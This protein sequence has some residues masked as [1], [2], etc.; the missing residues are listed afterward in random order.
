[1]FSPRDSST[2]LGMTAV[3]LLQ[4][5]SFWNENAIEQIKTPLHEQRQHSSGNRTL[6]N[7]HVI[8]QVKTAYDRFAQTASADQRGE[9]GSSNINHG[10]GFDSGEDGSRCHR[11]K[12]LPKAR[13]WA[14]SQCNRGFAQ[15][16]WNVLQTGRGVAHDRQQTVQKK[17]GDGGRNA[18]SKKG[19]G[20]KQGEQ[21][22]RR[23]CLYNARETKN[24]M[25]NSTAATRD[26]A[27]RNPDDD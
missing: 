15:C 6:E 26:N 12:N 13:D 19:K 9:R 24:N 23:N 8:V 27:K 1:I 25:A 10:A 14:E 16:S 2:S 7:G 11:H 17:R 21:R 20:Y 4:P 22:E 5:Q 3:R 18:N